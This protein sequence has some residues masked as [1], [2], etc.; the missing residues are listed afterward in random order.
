MIDHGDE[1][2]QHRENQSCTEEGASRAKIVFAFLLEAF[3]IT[4]TTSESQPRI[5]NGSRQARQYNGKRSF[6]SYKGLET[7]TD[8]VGVG[9]DEAKRDQPVLKFVGNLGE[10]R[11][12]SSL[13]HIKSFVMLRRLFETR[14]K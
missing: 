11:V 10:R 2:N 6:R 1:W 3:P 8:G 9:G 4:V 12:P 7:I 14:S 13:I 5:S